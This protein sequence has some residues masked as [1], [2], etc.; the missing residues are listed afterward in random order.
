[1]IK[2]GMLYGLLFVSLSVIPCCSSAPKK[3][4]TIIRGDYTFA[5]KYLDWIVAETMKKDRITGAVVAVVDAKEIICTRAYGY[6][7]K[8]ER[9]PMKS[10]TFFR[11]GS[12]SKSF[13]ALGIMKL[14]CR[15]EIDLD[16][17]VSGYIPGFDIK[18]HFSQTPQM[19]TRHLLSHK[20]G[21][22][23]DYYY[24]IMGGHITGNEEL[25]SALADEYFC[26]PPGEAFK[27]SNIG[28]TLLGMI[29]EGAS[30][31][32]YEQYMKEEIL[33]PLGMAESSFSLSGYIEPRLAKGYVRESLVLIPKLGETPKMV[34]APELELRDKPAG[35][36]YSNLPELIRFLQYL[37]SDKD[38]SPTGIV[39][40]NVFAGMLELSF[41]EAE[42][43][44]LLYMDYGLGF[45]TRFFAYRDIAD[46]AGHNGWI[47]GFSTLFVFSPQS[48]M[49]MIIL[50]NADTGN[51]ACSEIVSSSFGNFIEAK[52]G[53]AVLPLDEGKEAGRRWKP[54]TEELS[55]FEGKYAMIGVSIDVYRRGRDLFCKTSIMDTEFLLVPVEPGLFKPVFSFLFLHFD[56]AGFAGYHTVYFRFTV[57]SK[58]TAYLFIEASVAQQ[59]THLSLVGLKHDK[60]PGVFERRCGI[61]EIVSSEETREVLDMY[62]PTKEYEL[63]IDNGWLT[64]KSR[65][66]SPEISLILLPV[67]E[68][69]AI[70]PGSGETVHFGE[71]HF[72]FSGFEARKRK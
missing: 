53:E 22:I 52:T 10:E 8:E 68:N 2:K 48:D 51:K 67:S 3:P 55:V 41:P 6:A 4:E 13:T 18:S 14:A 40:E 57:N 37:L 44:S 54:S 31:S 20:G 70:I 24:G 34:Q 69:E 7:D 27:Y 66:L 72:T 59:V 45:M 30:G 15:G 61:Y 65:N 35:G 19:T 42:D 62:L 36:L 29:I 5:V 56:I 58:G 38:A 49:A 9:I 71:S 60:I 28:Y 16:K 47:N 32:T 64:V 63:V 12:I 21:M 50:T 25:L 33:E 43:Y 17:P 1:M 46:I 11:V 26:F 23:R 39:S